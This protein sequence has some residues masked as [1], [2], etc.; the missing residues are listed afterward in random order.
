MENIIINEPSKPF[1]PLVSFN[2]ETGICS[3][4]GDSYLENAFEFYDNLAK[5][6]AQYCRQ[7]PK[8]LQ[9]FIKL[10]YFNT[11]SSRSLL[12]FF[13]ALRKVQAGG[14]K[15]SVIW[16]YPDADSD[17]LADGE[18]FIYESELDME[19]REYDATISE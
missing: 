12:D 8:P 16:Y 7:Q 10:K 2:A 19:L 6:I 5:W 15:L 17:L 4:S 9:L 11:S 13:K 18:D 14:G 1:F 3:I